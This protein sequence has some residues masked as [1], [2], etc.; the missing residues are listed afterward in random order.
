MGDRSSLSSVP[1]NFVVAPQ[2]WTTNDRTRN[3]TV[4]AL[5]TFV[6]GDT[7]RLRTNDQPMGPLMRL[8]EVGTNPR[9]HI[10]TAMHLERKTSFDALSGG[11]KRP[12]P[13]RFHIKTLDCPVFSPP[14]TSSSPHA[15]S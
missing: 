6:T 15:Q 9:S 5:D 7:H 4:L 14:Q 8:V 13:S 12:A 1:C 10:K 11:R 2:L 3:G